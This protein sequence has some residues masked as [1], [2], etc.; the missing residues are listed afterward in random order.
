MRP[1]RPNSTGCQ[2]TNGTPHGTFIGQHSRM[3][4]TPR[5]P[6]RSCSVRRMTQR[7]EVRPTLCARY[8]AQS[9]TM[10]GYPFKPC[11]STTSTDLFQPKFP[12]THSS[13]IEAHRKFLCSAR[14]T[15]PCYNSEMLKH[16]NRAR[17]TSE[18]APW[19]TRCDLTL[20]ADEPTCPKE[21]NRLVRT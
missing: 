16:R 15:T 11:V 20:S 1:C 3:V 13:S 8:H 18:S 14:S 21:G 4:P 7:E 12:C 2:H 5:K 17:Y 10:T 19:L 6:I 9:A